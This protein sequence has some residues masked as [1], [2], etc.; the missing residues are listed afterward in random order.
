MDF[1]KIK[2]NGRYFVKDGHYL[3]PNGGSGF[4]FK[5]QGNSF[6]LLL[7]SKPVECYYYIIIDRNYFNK[8]KNNTKDGLYQHFFQDDKPH[9]IDIVKA[10][11][12]NDN[13]LE[14]VNLNIKGELLDD[15]FV[16]SKR[17]K[18][19]GDSTVAGY[20]ILSHDGEASIHTSDAV[21]DFVYRS[22]YELNMEANI[23]SASGWGLVFSAYTRPNNIGIINYIDKVAV[24]KDYPWKDKTQYDLLIISLGT[25]DQS[26]IESDQKLKRQRITQFK[27]AYKS[28]IEQELKCHK[29]L[30]ILMIYGTLKEENVYYLIEET[31]QELKPL[32]QNLFIHK[33]NGDN[34]AI[35]NHAYV[36]KHDE[37]SQELTAV[38]KQIMLL[39]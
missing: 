5:M 12:A 4:S 31:Y 18:V 19:Y 24:Y 16:Y 11:E 9:Y 13:C 35:S 27:E 36:N 33:F 22:L 25:N 14:L 1:N 28:L 2:L 10:N 3:F 6:S 7:E 32:Y 34:S 30:K 38:I 8:I 39:A 15:D 21:R 29:N 26:Y 37:M 17:V 20:G 23:L